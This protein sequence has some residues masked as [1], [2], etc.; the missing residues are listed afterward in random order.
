MLRISDPYCAIKFIFPLQTDNLIYGTCVELRSAAARKKRKHSII[1]FNGF[2]PRPQWRCH[3]GMALTCCL[4]SCS[5]CFM[6][7]ME[8]SGSLDSKGTQC[9]AGKRTSCL[10]FSSCIRFSEDGFMF[11]GCEKRVTHRCMWP[12]D[13]RLSNMLL[14]WRMNM[15]KKSL[16]DHICTM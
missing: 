16:N 2:I 13:I 3:P 5:A 14:L 6:K 1:T 11:S 10:I 9:V 4:V 12:A 15:N 7:M 8:A